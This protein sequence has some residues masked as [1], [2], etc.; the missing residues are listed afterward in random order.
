LKPLP[1]LGCRILQRRNPGGNNK[2]REWLVPDDITMAIATTLATKGAEVLVNGTTCALAALAR[3]VRRRLGAGHAAL[4]GT[5]RDPA[6][7][8]DA[9]SAAMA[10][11]PD[12]ARQLLDL[13]RRTD[14]PGDTSVNRFSGHAAGVVQAGS[15][16]G[17]VHFHGVHRDPTPVPRQLPPAPPFLTGRDAELAALDQLLDGDT[18]R[19]AFAVLSGPG[20]VGKTALAVW[21]AHRT[22]DRF[23][24]GQLHVDLGGFSGLEP[25]APQEALALLLRALGTAPDA[26]PVTL[27]ERTALYRSLTARGRHLVVLDGAHSVAQVRVLR[28]ASPSSAVL[29]TS[30]YHLMGLAPDG[31]R[32]IEVHPLPDATAVALLSRTVGAGRLAAEPDAA[33]AVARHCHGLP[34]ALCVAAAWLASRPRASVARMASRLADEEHRLAA[35]STGTDNSVPAVFDVSYSMLDPPA[36]TL[37]RRLGLH[38]GAEFGA[39][40]AGAVLGT[41]P[42]AATDLL[43]QLVE[44]NLVEELSDDRFRLH[45]LLRLHARQRAEADE[46]ANERNGATR[47][48]L[49]WYLAAALVADELVTPGRPRLPYAYQHPPVEVPSF[50]DRDEALD[51][52]ERERANLVLA[53]RTAMRLELPE[54]AWHLSYVMWPLLLYRKHYEDRR[55]IDE[56]GVAAARAWGNRWAQANM[57]KRLGRTVGTLG[58]HTAA[59]RHTRAAIELYRQAGDERHT[60]NALTGLAELFRDAGRPRAAAEVLTE[61][62]A[63]DRELGDD[64]ATGLALRAL[65]SVLVELSEPGQALAPLREADRLLSTL[66]PPDPYNRFRVTIAVAAA[67]LGTGD[68]AAAERAARQAAEGMRRLGAAR[69]EAEALD[70]LGRTKQA[71]GDP[72]AADHYRAALALLDGLG[73]RHAA[74]LR[75]RLAELDGTPP[76]PAATPEPG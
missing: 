62:I 70:L 74:A 75:R 56:R 21:W 3:L 52:L 2:I 34:L 55:E 41:I 14:Q 9:L 29:A 67:A 33:E 51:W 13:W 37:Y 61:V 72:A 40:V 35:L 31:A 58:D 16:H 48:V 23:P 73:A 38:P 28:P 8:A 57:L 27:A 53:G 68:L 69:E 39:G 18:P 42:G 64:R 26:I 15:I 1:A 22:Q 17:D 76:P 7:L 4:D 65:G 49:E 45:D 71:R 50:A 32:L 20:G 46:T 5:P 19:P 60:V 44:V 10:A 63:A 54:L 6:A 59:E 30:R 11:D 12:F 47:A 43:D 24:D 66:D 36:A 25:V